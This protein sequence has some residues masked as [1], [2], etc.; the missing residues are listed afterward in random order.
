VSK[1][2]VEIKGFNELQ[3]KLKI[4]GDDKTK[5]REVRKILGQVANTTVKVA[6]RLAPKSKKAHSIS[7]K[8][9]ATKVYQP[10]NLKKSIGKKMLTRSRIPML[11]I[12]AKSGKKAD[13]W[14]GRQMVIRGTKFQDSN[15]FMD[16]AIKE[17][18]RKVTADGEQRIAKYIQKQINKLS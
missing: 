18:N 5:T 9:R 13:G 17:T 14:Y 1:A 10:G 11:V 16:E 8:T 2:L 7:G 6:K 15:P 4:L 12:R 3:T